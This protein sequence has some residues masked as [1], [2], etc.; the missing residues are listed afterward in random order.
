MKKLQA[1]INQYA[2]FRYMQ[3]TSAESIQSGDKWYCEL[4]LIRKAQFME[5]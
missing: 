4:C 3:K 5:E 1:V 2:Y